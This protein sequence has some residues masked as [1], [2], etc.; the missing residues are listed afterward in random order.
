MAAEGPWGAGS[1]AA[2]S[3]CFSTQQLCGSCPVLPGAGAGEAR[4]V[5]VYLHTG[6]AARLLLKALVVCFLA[7]N[8]L[9][10]ENCF[11]SS[12]WAWGQ[13]PMERDVEL[14]KLWALPPA[15]FHRRHQ[16]SPGHGANDK[17]MIGK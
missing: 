16:T 1:T 7:V 6:R 11:L 8:T 13:A 3:F 10:A 2:L 9:T 15:C 14:A 12:S 5:S 17:E 4:G